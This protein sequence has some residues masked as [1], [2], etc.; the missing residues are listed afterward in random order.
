MKTI[1]FWTEIACLYGSQNSPVIFCMEKSVPSIR[2]TSL[3]W[4]QPSRVVFG[5]KTAT[6]GP[7]KQVSM[8]PRHDL[9]LCERKRAWF[10]SDSLVSMCPNPHLC[11]FFMQ[12]SAFWTRISGLYGSQT[13]SVVFS[14]HNCELNTRIKR[15]YLYQPSPVALCMQNSTFWTRVTSLYGSQTWPVVLCMQYSVISTRITCLYGS[16]PLSVVFACKTAT[17]GAELQLSMCHSSHLWFLHTQQLILDQN[18]KSVRVPDF[19]CGF[20]HT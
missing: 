17:F 9:S 20:E 14:T 6:Y 15:L 10:A 7:E 13:S 18:F 3:H 1:G 19:I 12:Y 4:S 11:L 16:Q 8:G 5:C 2:N